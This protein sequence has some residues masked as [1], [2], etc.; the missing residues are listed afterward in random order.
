MLGLIGGAIG[1]VIGIGIS[2]IV[3]QIAIQQLGSGLL[4]AYLGLPLIIGA[5][6]FSFLVGT[7]SGLVPAR[8]ASRLYPV[9]ALRYE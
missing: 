4:E 7:I 9:D 6:I 2:K 8:K 5:L 3:E 1:V